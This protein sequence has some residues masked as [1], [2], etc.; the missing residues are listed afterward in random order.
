MNTTLATLARDALAVATLLGK[1][2]AE[3]LR[4]ESALVTD[5]EGYAWLYVNANSG[6]LEDAVIDVVAL[7]RDFYA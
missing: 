1:S 4:L 3:V 5:L 6:Y 2:E 7:V